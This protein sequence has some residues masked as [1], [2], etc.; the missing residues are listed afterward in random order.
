MDEK[1]IPEI[2]RYEKAIAPANCIH[3]ISPSMINK[4]FSYPKM[5]YEEEIAKTKPRDFQGNTASVMGTIC[6]HVY[7]CVANKEPISKVEGQSDRDYVNEQLDLFATLKPELQLDVDDIKVNWPLVSMAVVNQ[8]ILPNSVGRILTEYKIQCEIS[9]NVY[10]GG[11]FDRLEGD[12]LIDF[13][14]VSQKPSNTE[15]IPFE[16]KIQLLAYAW[17]LRKK[18]HEVNRIRVVY[19][20]KPTKTIEA[21][22]Y[23]VTETIDYVADKLINDTLQLITES[24]VIC[25]NRPEL[26]HLI[27]KSMELKK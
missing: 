1:L 12:C 14:N 8:Y 3:M 17:M 15:T 19:G 7:K 20:V 9:D 2:F 18:G 4:F 10:I 23:P 16:Y 22:C 11:T 25:K 13:K 6:H 24:I 26:I 21:R 27:F 5:Y